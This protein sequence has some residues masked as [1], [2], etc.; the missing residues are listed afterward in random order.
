M[1]LSGINEDSRMDKKKGP[2]F[3]AN[4]NPIKTKIGEANNLPKDK[5]KEA[6]EENST[7]EESNVT[8]VEVTTEDV[9]KNTVNEVPKT[10]S[11]DIGTENKEEKKATDKKSKKEKSVKPVAQLGLQYNK[12]KEKRNVQKLVLI[13]PTMNKTVND[14]LKSTYDEMPFNTLVNYLLKEFIEKHDIEVSD[15]TF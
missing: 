11:T 5:E 12:K 6:S 3:T 8:T 1:A 9:T 2:D 10:A 4:L 13:T 7:T 14:L 15:D